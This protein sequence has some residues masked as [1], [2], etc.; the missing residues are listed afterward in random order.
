MISKFRALAFGAIA[1]SALGAPAMAE[2]EPVR[3]GVL[4]PLSGTFTEYGKQMQNGLQ[5]FLKQH[6]DVA[7][8]RK[9][10]LIFKD[11]GGIA[12]EK[13]KKAAQELLVRDH[14]DVLA[15]FAFTASALAVAPLAKESARPMIVMNA[16]ASGITAASPTMMRVGQTLPQITEPAGAW[17]AKNGRD[18]VF[19]LVADIKAGQDAEAAFIRGL[20][21]GGGQVV[22]S[23]RV[24]AQNPDFAPF[25]QRIKDARP[26]AVFVWLPP[27]E[28]TIAFIKGFNER[29]LGAA[30]IELLGTGD[31]TDD[32]D[33]EAEGD[34]ALGVLTTGHYSMAHNSSLNKRFVTEYRAAFP[35]EKRPNFLSVSAYD[36]LALIYA[37]LDKTGGKTDA[38][39]F[40]AA[41]KGV[42]LESPRGPIEIDADTRDI[43]QTVY[44][45]K[46]EK[47]NGKL[48]N[49][50]FDS[51]PHARDLSK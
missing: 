19:T 5:L 32:L 25:I 21:A 6:G 23:L 50:E 35:N 1:T 14:V 8:G 46:V 13:A 34:S 31:L 9:V 43:V 24:P 20:T 49:V 7:G 10:E 4:L 27:G 3:I 33:I 26:R 11:D 12:P 30:G 40:V 16:A 39:A 38:D 48:F 18:K 41:L 36:A 28:A 17:A 51:F 37:A 29:G 15:G 2:P 44:V 47:V 45:R 22:G 42:Q